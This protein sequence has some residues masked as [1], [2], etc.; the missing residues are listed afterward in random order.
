MRTESGK[1]LPEQ[2][3][4][5]GAEAVDIIEQAEED[6]GGGRRSGRTPGGIWT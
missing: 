5:F 1:E 4:L 6:D 3:L 2:F